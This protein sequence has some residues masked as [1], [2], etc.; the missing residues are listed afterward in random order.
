MPRDPGALFAWIRVAFREHERIDPTV[1]AA[2]AGALGGEL[3]R[4][5]MMP[6]RLK[7]FEQALAP[8]TSKLSP[9]ERTR[10]RNLAVVLT[11]SSTVKTFRS[12]LGVSA[13][14]AAG[15]VIWAL[16]SLI[17][18][19]IE[20]QGGDDGKRAPNRRRATEHGGP[21]AGPVYRSARHAGRAR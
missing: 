3:R 4:E 14:D 19:S 13:E 11:A 16:R 5:T 21:T 12:Y 8:V 7:M 2:M 10:L 20:Q 6:H 15:T 1:A 17:E 9:E 18:R